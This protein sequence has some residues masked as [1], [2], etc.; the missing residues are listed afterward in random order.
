MI[1]GYKIDGGA[2]RDL[3]KLSNEMVARIIKK[4]DYFVAS[5]RPLEF[6]E[7]L[8]NFSIGDYRFRVGDYRIIFD[9]EDETIVV[10]AVGHR[11]EIY[12]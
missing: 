9:V 2:V 10:L 6:A 4:M 11:R 8:S 3:Q 1:T 7:P 5:G 12:K